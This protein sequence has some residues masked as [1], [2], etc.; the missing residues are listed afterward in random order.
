MSYIT[1]NNKKN[2]IV[3]KI[4]EGEFSDDV[5]SVAVS[6][7]FSKINESPAGLQEIVLKKGYITPEYDAYSKGEL[8]LRCMIVGKSGCGKSHYAGMLIRSYKKQ[9]PNNDV[10]LFSALKSDKSLDKYDPIRITC[11]ESVYENPIELEELHNSL[12]V[13]DDIQAFANTKIALALNT[14]RDNIM[15][16]GRHENIGCLSLTQILRE[17]HKTKKAIRNTHQ[18]VF[19]PHLG[20]KSEME[21]Y[22]RDYIKMPIAEI[23]RATSLPSR[24]VCFS[25]SVPRFFMYEKGIY[26]SK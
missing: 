10:I 3:G 24:W 2:Q 25:E 23:R 13:F 9:F 18:I 1:L 4:H 8:P 12:C 6:S 16:T 7:D 15:T 5:I 22:L 20:G 26:I 17:G 11:D 21:S 14:L 19:F